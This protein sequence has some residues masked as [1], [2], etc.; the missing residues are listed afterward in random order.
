[1]LSALIERGVDFRRLRDHQGG[2]PCHVFTERLALQTTVGVAMLRS[3]ISR[4][5]NVRARDQFGV[6]CLHHAANCGTVAIARRTMLAAG[7]DVN[8][9]DNDGNTPLLFA[10]SHAFDP[11]KAVRALLALIVLGADVHAADHRGS[12]SL[13]AGRWRRVCHFTWFG[14]L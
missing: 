9:A 6:T 13:R 3:L 7:A 8:A 4:G 14:T 1:L 2:T 5:V 10:L 11:D 12:C